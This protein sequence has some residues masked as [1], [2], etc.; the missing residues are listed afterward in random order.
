[1]SLLMKLLPKIEKMFFPYLNPTSYLKDMKVKVKMKLESSFL[2][3]W[4]RRYWHTKFAS[5]DQFAAKEIFNCLHNTQFDVFH[6]TLPPF[7][8]VC[9]YYLRSTPTVA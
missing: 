4:L 3:L 5:F 7:V 6:T 8:T 1:M 2:I 9:N